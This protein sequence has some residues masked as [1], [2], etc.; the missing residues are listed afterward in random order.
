[1]HS[2][3]HFYVAEVIFSAH[4]GVNMTD[5]QNNCMERILKLQQI[6]TDWEF[7]V[8]IGRESV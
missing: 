8:F 7:L 5:V 3:E 6:G 4:S 1:M 2:S